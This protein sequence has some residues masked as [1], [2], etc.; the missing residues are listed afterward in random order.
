MDIRQIVVRGAHDVSL[1]TGRV[2]DVPEPGHVLIETEATFISAGTELAW[3]T[4]R[5]PQVTGPHGSSAYPR[6]PGYANCGRVLAVG[7]EVNDF[8]VGQRVFS[9]GRH[10]S[11]HHQTVHDPNQGML[12]HVPSDIAPDAA[13]AARMAMVAL[14]AVQTSTVQLNDWVAVLG[15]GSVGNLACQLFRLAGARVIGVDPLYAR[16]D[17]ARRVGDRA[18]GRRRPARSRAGRERSDR[19][20][21]NADHGRRGGRC[22]GCGAGRRAHGRIRR[23]RAA[24][25]AADGRT[26]PISMPSCGR[27]TISG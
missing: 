12:I 20:W 16:R 18:H 4:G 25:F 2:S 15:L 24:R 7:E 9:F 3:F 23:G 17:L 22:A 19:W 8:A 21:R 1:Q 27:C 6:V 13:A 10:V 11:H 14:T 26:R 5:D